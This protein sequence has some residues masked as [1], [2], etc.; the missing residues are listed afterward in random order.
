MRDPA[1][2]ASSAPLDG[3]ETQGLQT[4]TARQTL[5]DEHMAKAILAS[6]RT[7]LK[8]VQG[9][10]V[11]IQRHQLALL[12]S[13]VRRPVW[14][15]IT[16]R[17]KIEAD[18]KKAEELRQIAKF[19]D[20]VT[21]DVEFHPGQERAWGDFEKVGFAQ[22][23]GLGME[24]DGLNFRNL[25]IKPFS[26]LERMTIPT[27]PFTMIRLYEHEHVP[28]GGDQSNL[29]NSRGPSPIYAAWQNWERDRR[30]R[31]P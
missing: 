22:M 25:E 21:S 13:M 19:L 30:S 31:R 15:W 29:H 3:E 5:S 8:I 17:R 28:G 14:D 16:I 2:P 7:R 1:A 6:L 9:A 26:V 24:T 18:N 10:K 4:S 27:A 12:R 11:V 23:S 20:A